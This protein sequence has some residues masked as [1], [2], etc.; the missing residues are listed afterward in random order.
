MTNLNNVKITMAEFPDDYDWLQVKRRALITMG[1]KDV[2]T[3]PDQE[4]KHKILRAKHS[5][6]RRLMFSFNIENLPYW[7]STELSRHHIGYEKYIRSQRN[8]RQKEYDRNAA[9]QDTPV[10]MIWDITGEELLIIMNKRL[11]K[12]ADKTTRHVVELMR[13]QVLKV[14]PEFSDEMVPMCKYAGEC[15]E[16][17]P[18]GKMTKEN[19]NAE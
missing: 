14:C 13:N 7:L 9:R 6:I 18:C 19:N 1:F 11:C 17:F 3:M 8:D 5:P 15:K 10:N 12:L 16:M 2:K 4:W